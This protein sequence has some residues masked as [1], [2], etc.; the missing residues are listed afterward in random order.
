MTLRLQPL[1][2]H[3]KCSLTQERRCHKQ[4]DRSDQETSNE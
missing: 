2:Q 3:R 4:A 1:S